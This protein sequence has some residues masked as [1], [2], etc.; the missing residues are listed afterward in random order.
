M[1]NEISKSTFG[2]RVKALRK[3]S[4]KTQVSLALALNTDASTISRWENDERQPDY[5]ML[6]DLAAE[7]KTSECYLM[8]GK[9]NDASED[10]VDLSD[11]NFEQKHTIRTLVRL[12]RG[13]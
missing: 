11:L 8:Y 9:A 7:L 6:K 4:G 5:A 10:L 12:L 2:S 3:E 13:R 1:M